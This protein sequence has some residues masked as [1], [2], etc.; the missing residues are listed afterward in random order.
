M[1]KLL[2]RNW[3]VEPS[4]HVAPGWSRYCPET[5][6]CYFRDERPLFLSCGATARITHHLDTKYAQHVIR[7]RFPTS[8]H[9]YRRP[10]T[11]VFSGP[12]PLMRPEGG[13][14]PVDRNLEKLLLYE[15][16]SIYEN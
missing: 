4:A 10:K 12:A 2:C 16:G 9:R 7:C 6:K 5:R 1:L 13:A 8:N 15:I 11:P 14:V 3:K